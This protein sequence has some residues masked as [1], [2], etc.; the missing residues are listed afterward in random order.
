MLIKN[1]KSGV[2]FQ[3]QKLVLFLWQEVF[4]YISFFVIFVSL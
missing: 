4:K 2:R 3:N 1:R